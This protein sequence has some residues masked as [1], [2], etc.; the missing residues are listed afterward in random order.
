MAASGLAVASQV[1]G[2]SNLLKVSHDSKKICMSRAYYSHGTVSGY[3][4]LGLCFSF[5]FVWNTVYWGELD[6]LNIGILI[7]LS[8]MSWFEFGVSLYL[9]EL[10]QIDKKYD[11][12]TCFCIGVLG[13]TM[14]STFFITGNP[15]L[16][17][18]SQ[19]ILA[20]RH[21]LMGARIIS[22]LA[23]LEQLETKISFM[24]EFKN[25]VFET[26]GREEQEMSDFGCFRLQD[27][28]ESSINETPNEIVKSYE[29]TLK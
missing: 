12:F 27:L 13:L 6:Y 10:H 16:A 17:L 21:F 25:I 4:T 14:L 11:N 2:A 3:F 9:I 29:C 26:E 22:H 7:L 23:D 8:F 19:V 15:V 5:G 20:V 18:L 1:V 24:A 28:E